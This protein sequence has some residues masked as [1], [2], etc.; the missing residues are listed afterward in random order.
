MAPRIEGQIGLDDS[1]FQAGLGRVSKSV[2]AFGTGALSRFGGLIAGAFSAG[3]VMSFARGTGAAADRLADLSANLRIGVEELQT[4]EL[5]AARSGSSAETLDASLARLQKS[6]NAAAAGSKEAVKY[7]DVL[8]ISGA[9]VSQHQND[10]GWVVERV[11]KKIK[12]SGGDMRVADAAGRMLGKSY[13]ELNDTLNQVAAGGLVSIRNEMLANNEIMTAATVA[14]ANQMQEAYERMANRTK[15]TFRN[16]FTSIAGGMSALATI[17]QPRN[18]KQAAVANAGGGILVAMRNLFSSAAWSDAASDVFGAPK[19]V[20]MKTPA[21]RAAEQANAARIAA[22]TTA[23]RS[24]IQAADSYAKYGAFV[25]GQVNEHTNHAAKSAE[26]LRAIE[27]L[28][29]RS[30]SLAERSEQHLQSLIGEDE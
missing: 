29:S 12:D 26:L 5:I 10:L 1:L 6:L 27:R 11:A 23:G 14:A 25:G 13:V 3:A 20:G 4:L 19:G 24:T 2:E 7:L 28:Q 9:E 22:T 17:A 8:G 16:L 30:V 15:T 21:E 18:E